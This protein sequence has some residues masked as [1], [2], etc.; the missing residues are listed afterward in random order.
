MNTGNLQAC[1]FETDELAE[2]KR[3]EMCDVVKEGYSSRKI[4]QLP[5]DKRTEASKFYL[6]ETKSDANEENSTVIM[7]LFRCSTEPRIYIHINGDKT[8]QILWPLINGSETA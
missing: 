5:D 6:I 4:V 1:L 3:R 8:A 7:H 2:E